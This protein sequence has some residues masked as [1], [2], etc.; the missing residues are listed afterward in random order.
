MMG[1]QWARENVDTVVDWLEEEAKKRGLPF[2]RMAGRGLV[3]LA[4]RL[5]ERKVQSTVSV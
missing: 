3:T 5:A 2:V 1:C 4:I